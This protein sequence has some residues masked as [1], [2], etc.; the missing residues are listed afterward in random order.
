MSMIIKPDSSEEESEIVAPSFSS[1]PEI[2]LAIKDSRES[3]QNFEVKSSRSEKRNHN[4][5][6]EARLSGREYDLGEHRHSRSSKR[7]K[8]KKDYSSRSRSPSSDDY[9]YRKKKRDRYIREERSS[10]SRGADFEDRKRNYIETLFQERAVVKPL[11]SEQESPKP[12]EKIPKEF[13]NLDPSR[14]EAR[15][16]AKKKEKSTSKKE[17]RLKEKSKL[18]ESTQVQEEMSEEVIREKTRDF[19]ARLDQ[20][21]KDVDLWLEFIEFQD[22]SMQFGKSKKVD[23]AATRLSINEVKLSIFEKS[24]E[25]NPNE[26]ALLA[27]YL[28]CCEQ[29]WEYVLIIARALT[30]IIKKKPDLADFNHCILVYPDYSQDGINQCIQVFEDC[31]HILRKEVLASSN[32]EGWSQ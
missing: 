12:V 26:Q 29:V 1:F 19:N 22:K 21:P 11:V 32:S 14:S 25:S 15:Q 24:L 27:A 18:I 4:E 31:F 6:P 7:T 13:R 10:R 30:C 28:K 23:A 2:P 20:N 16:E 9:G 17:K 8:K 5:R 3:E